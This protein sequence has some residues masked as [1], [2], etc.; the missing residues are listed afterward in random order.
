MKDYKKT[1]IYKLESKDKDIS[2][3]YIGHTTTSINQRENMHRFMS[4][5]KSNCK[6]YN[7]IN[8]HGG[9]DNF[10]MTILEKYPCN[11]RIE[12]RE[13]ERELIEVFKPSLNSNL[14]NQGWKERRKK[15][16]E[17]YNTYMKNYM[18]KYNKKKMILRR[19]SDYIDEELWND[20]L[21]QI[22]TV[23]ID[24]NTFH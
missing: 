7:F 3:F 17:H 4:K 13:K 6:L 8:E 16:I 19:V 24:L 12:A 21:N 23:I 5:H 2:D 20:L 9:Y 11:N 1:I 15:N 14:P 10:Q 18:A 22:S